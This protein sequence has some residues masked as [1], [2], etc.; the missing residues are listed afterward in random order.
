MRVRM[1]VLSVEENRTKQR[2][3]VTWLIH[4]SL[5]H[6]SL[7]TFHSCT[8]LSSPVLPPCLPCLLL[9]L[10]SA[11]YQVVLAF[12]PLKMVS[13]T[14]ATVTPPWPR[15]W[16]RRPAVR[17]ES[18]WSATP[19]RSLLEDFHPTSM[20]V[21]KS[22]LHVEEGFHSSTPPCHK[23]KLIHTLRTQ[24][25]ASQYSLWLFALNSY[26]HTHVYIYIRL[27]S[28]HLDTPC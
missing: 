17:T 15:A 19:G 3:M 14:M 7:F 6:S 27:A 2:M 20:K 9:F 24:L 13:W 12:S 22:D 21:N 16:T 25:E 18:G 28:G 1:D 4:S 11:P 8:S 10:L 26:T 23:V 5:S